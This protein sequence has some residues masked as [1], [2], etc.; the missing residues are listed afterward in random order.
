M[1]KFFTLAIA[2]LFF[3][4]LA[5][6]AFAQ[7]NPEDTVFIEGKTVDTAL[8]GAPA[9]FLN[10]YITNKDS[11]TYFTLSLR[12]STVNGTAYAL[13]NKTGANPTFSTAVTPLTGTLRF[14]SASNFSQYNDNSPDRFLV[15]AGFDPGDPDNTI[16]PPNAA[17]KNVWQLKFRHS[18]GFDSTGIIRFDTIKTTLSTLFTNTAPADFVPN[19]VAGQCTVLV[20]TDVREVNQGQ[21]PKSYSLSQNYPNPFNANTQISFAL[22]KAGKTTL[23]VFNILGQKVNT[24][25]DEYLTAGTR[26]VNWDGWDVSGRE[27]PSG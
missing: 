18:S 9:F 11:L 5:T 12:E 21:R 7:I 22:P 20:G 16:E 8:T 26:I 17:R 25:V 24:L 14:F 2:F 10:V 1:K 13:V 3:A 15:A 23:E 27:V 19:F 6:T 4:A